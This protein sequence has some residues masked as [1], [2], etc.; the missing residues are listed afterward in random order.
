LNAEFGVV[1]DDE[2]FAGQ[3]EHAFARDLAL[4]APVTRADLTRVSLL[5]RTLDVICYWIRAQL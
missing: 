2:S 4:S 5:D 1:I 3:L